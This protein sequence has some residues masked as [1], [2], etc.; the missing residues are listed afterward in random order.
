MGEEEEAAAQRGVHVAARTLVAWILMLCAGSAAA[1]GKGISPQETARLEL[2]KDVSEVIWLRDDRYRVEFRLALSNTGSADVRDIQVSDDFAREMAPARILTVT[3]PEISG[4]LSQPNPLFDGQTSIGLLSGDELL[5]AGASAVIRVTAEF[6]VASGSG[7]LFNQARAW[8]KD[9]SSWMSVSTCSRPTY[10]E[11]TSTKQKTA[12]KPTRIELPP[13]PAHIGLAKAAAAP[14]WLGDGW[15]RSRMRFVVR[16]YGDSKAHDVQILDDLNATFGSTADFRLEALSSAWAVNDSFDGIDDIELLRPGAY[17]LPSAEMSVDLVVDFRPTAAIRL[18]IFNRACARADG[19]DCDESQDGPDPDPDHDE[20]PREMKKTLIFEP[21]PVIGVANAASPVRYLGDRQVA[22]DLEITLRNMGNTPL[23]QITANN[24]LAA[25]FGTEVIT[26]SIVPGTLQSDDL[27]VN[28]AFDGERQTNLLGPGGSLGQDETAAVRVSVVFEP[29]A[30][31]GAFENHVIAST[32]QGPNDRSTDGFEPDPDGNRVPD[33]QAPTPISYKLPPP[34]PPPQIGLAKSSTSCSTTGPGETEARVTF[35]VANLGS[36]PLTG[37]RLEDDLSRTFPSPATFEVVDG[38]LQSDRLTVNPHFD[39]S[40][41]TELLATEINGLAVQ[42]RATISLLVRYQPNDLSGPYINQASVT[43]A[44]GATDISNAGQDPYA[45][46]EN[47]TE[48]CEVPPPP[49]LADLAVEKTL[50]SISDVADTDDTWQADFRID[51][52]NTGEARLH[53]LQVMDDLGDTF[54][55]PTT[56]SVIGSPRVSGAIESANAGFG[57]GSFAL[58]SGSESLAAGAQGHIEFSVRFTVN[59]ETEVFFNETFAS[60]LDPDG[61]PV[62][63]ESDE[64]TRVEV[65]GALEGIVYLDVDHDR[66]F[67]PGE[68]QTLDGWVV[69]LFDDRFQAVPLAERP[70]ADK[71]ETP[72]SGA[73][74]MNAIPPGNYTVLFRHPETEVAWKLVQISIQ[75]RGL[76]VVD[77]P[78]DPQGILYDAGERI[79][80]PGARLSI[81]DASEVPL[82]ESCLLPGQQDQ[83]VGSNGWYRFTLLHG[84]HEHCPIEAREYRITISGVPE[85]TAEQPIR[86]R[87]GLSRTLPPVDAVYDAD[88]CSTEPCLIQPQREVPAAGTDTR[89][90][91]RINTGQLS[92]TVVNNHFPID[93]ETTFSSNSKPNLTIDKSANRRRVSISGV[94][95]YTL[96]LTNHTRTPIP[97]VSISDQPPP[98]FQLQTD[99]GLLFRAGDDGVLGTSDDERSPL[100]ATGTTTVTF[101]PIAFDPEEQVEVRY[102]SR[103]SPA[104]KRGTHINT[105]TASYR[106]EGA[107]FQVS[108]DAAVEVAA[109]PL[110]SRA[111]VIGKVFHDVNND[112]VQGPFERGMY[113]ARLITPEGLLIETD[114]DGRYHIADIDVTRDYG[115]NYVIKLDV[116]TLPSGWYSRSDPRQ[117]VHL[118]PGG[119]GKVNWAVTTPNP[120]LIGKDCCGVYRNFRFMDPYSTEKRLDVYPAHITAMPD[121]SDQ[122]ERWTLEFSVSS[123][124][125]VQAPFFQ[126][127]LSTPDDPNFARPLARQCGVLETPHQFVRMADLATANRGRDLIYRMRVMELAGDNLDDYRLELSEGQEPGRY[128]ALECGDPPFARTEHEISRAFDTSHTL[129]LHLPRRSTDSDDAKT[130]WAG[131]RSISPGSALAKQ[132]ILINRATQARA[133]RRYLTGEPARLDAR[134]SLVTTQSQLREDL[135]GNP[136]WQVGPKAR[137]LPDSTTRGTT[138]PSPQHILDESRPLNPGIEMEVAFDRSPASAGRTW[139]DRN[140]LYQPHSTIYSAEGLETSMFCCDLE[141]SVETVVDEDNDIYAIRIQNRSHAAM[142]PAIVG[143]STRCAAPPVDPIPPYTTRE[144]FL[145]NFRNGPDALDCWQDFTVQIRSDLLPGEPRMEYHI[146]RGRLEENGQWRPPRTTARCLDVEGT[147]QIRENLGVVAI[148]LEDNEA[149]PRT[150]VTGQT[151][152]LNSASNFGVAVLDLTF[153]GR[154]AEGDL[155]TLVE[156]LDLDGTIADG[157]VAAYWRGVKNKGEDEDFK[158]VV[159]LDSSKDELSN[160]FDNLSSKDPDRIF[161]QLDTD[162]YYPT[163]G[164]D[165]TTLLDTESQGAIYARIASNRS[166]ALWGNFNTGFTDTEFAQFNRSLYGAYGEYQTRSQTEG[167]DS[168][169]QLKGF[170]SDAET[171]SGRA[172][173]LATGGSLYYLPHTDIVMGSEK[174]WVEV[175]RR[176]TEQ[177]EEREVLLPGR[178]YEVDPLQGRILLQSPLSQVVRERFNNVIRSRPLEGDDVYLFVNYEYV[179]R[180]LEQNDGTFGLRGQGWIGQRLA[181]GA[182]HATDEEGVETYQ[183]N[184]LDL[185]WRAGSDSYISAEVARSESET[186]GSQAFS[187]DGGLTFEADPFARQQASE[188]HDAYGF[189][190]RINLNDFTADRDGILRAWWKSREEGFSSG[191]FAAGP[192]T[193]DMGLDFEGSLTDEWTLSGGATALEREGDRTITTA[194]VQAGGQWSCDKRKTGCTELEFEV[195]HED[196][197]IAAA[198]PGTL[199]FRAPDGSATLFGTRAAFWL[200]EATSIYGTAQSAIITE[201]D[202]GANDLIALGTNTRVNDRLALSLEASNGDRGEALV[203]GADFKMSERASFNL[204]GGAG[205]GALSRFSG[206]YELSEGHELFG[207]YT[208]DP[209]RTDGRRNLLSVGQRKHFGDRTRIFTE[210]Q[211][212]RGFGETSAGHM[213]GIEFDKGDWVLSTTLQASE[214]KRNTSSFDRLAASLGATYQNDRTRL[215]TRF[216]LREDNGPDVDARQYVS[217]NA[218]AHQLNKDGRLIGKLNVAWTDDRFSDVEAGRFAEIALG[219]AYRPLADDRLNGMVRYTYLH[220]VGT[221]GQSNSPGDEKAHVVSA[222]GFYDITP[223]LQLGGK[224]AY[225]GGKSR[226][227]KGTGAWYDLSLGMVIARASYHIDLPKG[228]VSANLLP[229]QIELLGEYRWLEDFEGESSQRGALLGVYRAFDPRHR[230]GAQ[231]EPGKLRVVPAT[232]RVGVG[233]NFSGFDDDMHKDNYRSHGWFL[234]MMAVF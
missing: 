135:L 162:H 157:R 194:R 1:V 126:L 146:R 144:Y 8:A 206:R 184:G 5:K 139:L 159:Q 44:E 168:W 187:L 198:P 180:N 120:G 178:D 62:Y 49:I 119:I 87:T 223:R 226:V 222:E 106:F 102:V 63:A 73:F 43:S 116:N 113:K 145:G 21:D 136:I 192:E 4:A 105:A 138:D 47:G 217:S 89:Y 160:L 77:L 137:H 210:S 28:P 85:V 191:R 16:N 79:A 208:M 213:G 171:T 143:V 64:P 27:P 127:S 214:V 230:A 52:S 51:V 34:P 173:F 3:T 69:A 172:A 155:D 65:P 179:A 23:S 112:G 205:A 20:D 91:A 61:Q 78:I 13:T 219:Y 129:A 158:W 14:E 209:D 232:L 103:V 153:G 109:D 40:A 215:S 88:S 70:L 140:V 54:P 24:A 90:F 100:G 83:P 107:E 200:D 229:D 234:D 181:L 212:G 48:I 22:F 33:E 177:V 164:D 39:G 128:P 231:T 37:L 221:E 58:L 96:R 41:D 82:P 150:N 216:E 86:Y 197:D 211:F 104:V 36:V 167:G 233:Y 203:A 60:A 142:T 11:S 225:R 97:E 31:E 130:S 66:A 7:P 118:A 161:R 38:S 80:V 166:H 50:L 76:E 115:A 186:G 174:V 195:R 74:A 32:E 182:T 55:A 46:G 114:K 169:F 84:A 151:A 72:E 111:T 42:E 71:R 57:R 141:T 196:V 156:T 123:N 176:D 185:L 19:T 152:P 170:F 75:P 163:Y 92:P 17:L 6:T 26:Y 99:S 15:F 94:V 227:E 131:Q 189:E 218:F 110:F 125:Y 45:E 207:T 202:Y 122:P 12:C 59:D 18:P 228:Q 30:D 93:R 183:L 154:T 121:S 190:A 81:L 149:F 29:V 165:S 134:D 133:L 117:I 53:N 148:R 35:H 175:R 56:F 108:D 124:Y 2:H 220:D 25:M 10:H 224:L 101:D 9:S 193:T 67:T 204:A 201:R 188:R 132:G 147:P 199:P 95:L 98:G 68:D